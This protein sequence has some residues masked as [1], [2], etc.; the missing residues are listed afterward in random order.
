MNGA[1]NTLG[2]PLGF[3]A[4]PLQLGLAEVALVSTWSTLL[5]VD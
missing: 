1:F 3:P 5:V 4:E 2:Y